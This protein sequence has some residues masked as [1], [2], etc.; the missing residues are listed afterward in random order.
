MAGFTS[1]DRYRQLFL[2]G[3]DVIGLTLNQRQTIENFAQKHWE[4]RPWLR[5]VA[6]R[7]KNH[8]TASMGALT[9]ST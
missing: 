6:R 4:C 1:C 5:N 2:E 7:I 9:G 8:I 3:V